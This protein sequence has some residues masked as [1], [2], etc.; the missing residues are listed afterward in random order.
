M[1][2]YPRAR[3]PKILLNTWSIKGV[4]V[5]GCVAR[6]DG[7]SFRSKAHAHIIGRYTGWLC[8]RRADRLM[9]ESLV[10]HELAHLTTGHGHDDTWRAEVMRLGGTLEPVAGI[11]GDYRKKVHE[12]T[13]VS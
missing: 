10:I 11:I 2:S 7:S 9:C 6:G 3:W 8:F 12:R 5:G 13:G 1:P 4:Y